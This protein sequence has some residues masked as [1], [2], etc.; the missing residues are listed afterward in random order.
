[1]ELDN[2]KTIW[3]DVGT[4]ATSTSVEELEQLLSKRSKSPI[5]KLKRNLFWEMVV[6]VVIYGATILYYLFQNQPGML[7]L[8]LMMAVIGG[9]YGWYYIVKRKLLIHMECVTCEV[10]SNLSSQLVSLE[11]LVKLYLW[12]GTLLVPVI[13]MI[14]AMIVYFTTP[15]PQEIAMSKR[16]FF[17]YFFI[18][19]LLISLVCTIPLFF[20]NK[21]YIHLLYG[22]HIKQLRAIVNEMNELPFQ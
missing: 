16:A 22:R 3:K 15:L 13:L 12:A 14:S 20:L 1:M 11:K 4:T 2:L 7:Y 21:W 9:L 19:L 10:K 5:A 8:A 17:V 6:V 18:A